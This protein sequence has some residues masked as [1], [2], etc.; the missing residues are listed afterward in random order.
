MRTIMIVD[1]DPLLC[2]ALQ[3][4]FER[5]GYQVCA[6]GN[7]Q[8]LLAHLEVRQPDLILLDLMMP[9][10]SGIEVLKHLRR[11]PAPSSIPVLVMTA[12][13]HSD[14]RAKCLELGA[15][16]VVAKP[17]SLGELVMQ[18][19]EHLARGQA[20]VS[21]K[22]KRIEGDRQKQASEGIPQQVAKPRGNA[23]VV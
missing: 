15:A 17:F 10:M 22:G 6:G 4:K 8:D 16:G 13:D 14:I 20:G 23:Q 19:E 5:A 11:D 7:G 1:D 2:A 18:V 3:F 21:G 12:W 9:D